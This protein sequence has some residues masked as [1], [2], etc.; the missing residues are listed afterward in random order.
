MEE[1]EGLI[2]IVGKV[3]LTFCKYKL[4]EYQYAH[5]GQKRFDMLVWH[6]AYCFRH[7]NENDVSRRCDPRDSCSTSVIDSWSC[8]EVETWLFSNFP[9]SRPEFAGRSLWC[10]VCAGKVLSCFH[11]TPSNFEKLHSIAFSLPFPKVF[12]C[13][14]LRW[15]F[16]SWKLSEMSRCDQSSMADSDDLPLTLVFEEDVPLARLLQGDGAQASRTFQRCEFQ[17]YC[18]KEVCL[19][20]LCIQ[21]LC[22]ITLVRRKVNSALVCENKPCCDL[23]KR[24]LA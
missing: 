22:P 15:S 18:V 12:K 2:S 20:A 21:V 19:Q 13:T 5:S 3:Q 16:H 1:F 23:V 6:Q 11:W 9:W 8:Q 14:D 24:A 4:C 7:M 17:R 10:S